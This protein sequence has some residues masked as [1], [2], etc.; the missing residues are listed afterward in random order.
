MRF[1]APKLFDKP[2][3]SVVAM[4]AAAQSRGD[5]STD[6][7]DDNDDDYD[8]SA[9]DD[10]RRVDV[11][12]KQRR[13]INKADSEARLMDRGAALLQR[14]RQRLARGG[15]VH[16]FSHVQTLDVSD[17]GVGDEF[18]VFLAHLT[19][20]Q[21]LVCANNNVARP[22]HAVTQLTNLNSLD[23]RHNRVRAIDDA[24]RHLTAL[25]T[26]LLDHN[27][28]DT[29][30]NYVGGLPRLRVLGLSH[31]RLLKMPASLGLLVHLAELKLDAN[32]AMTWPPPAICS[33]GYIAL[34]LFFILL[35]K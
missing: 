5:D 11:V 21:Q 13:N 23:L 24:V 28:I 35:L 19:A 34:L 7:D 6:G 17:C 15:R 1:N 31:N 3:R 32:S 8:D 4:R 27:V 25:E 30:S 12:A 20:L 29:V 16:E 2:T 9:A 26:L 18:G 33:K 14:R 22:W 10:S